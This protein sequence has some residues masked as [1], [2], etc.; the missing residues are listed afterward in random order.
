MQTNE[1]TPVG[2]LTGGAAVKLLSLW[3]ADRGDRRTVDEYL[4][5]G[6]AGKLTGSD[7]VPFE[8]VAHHL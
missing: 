8:S 1:P 2:T 5:D 4:A 3:L 6:Y 7:A